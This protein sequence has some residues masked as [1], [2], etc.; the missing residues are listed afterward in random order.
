MS[1]LSSK[2]DWWAGRLAVVPLLLVIACVEVTEATGPGS[3]AALRKASRRG[4]VSRVRNLIAGGAD[5][6]SPDLEGRTALHWAAF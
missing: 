5:L 6:N 1:K 4:D 3:A 2:A